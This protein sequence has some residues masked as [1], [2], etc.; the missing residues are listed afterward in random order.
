MKLPDSTVVNRFLAK[1][2]FYKRA[3][4]DTKLKQLFTDEVEKITWAHKISA[5]TLNIESAKYIELQIIEILLKGSNLSDKVLFSIDSAIPYPVIFI[6]KRADQ[7]NALASFMDAPVEGVP[8]KKNTNYYSTGWRDDLQ[9]ELRGRSVDEIYSN[10]LYQI[11][12]NLKAVKKGEIKETVETTSAIEKLKL[13][14]ARIN[15]KISNELSIS[16]RQELARQRHAI[17]AQ[18]EDMLQ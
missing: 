13:E 15:K 8:A 1:E 18:I 4:A 5:D 14:I 6:V 16:K 3:K 10:F 12:P 2:R 11:S 7:L 17:E 9:L